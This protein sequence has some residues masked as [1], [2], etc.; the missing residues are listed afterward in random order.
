[1]LQEYSE[2]L[3]TDKP[4]VLKFY[5]SWCKPCQE[6][7]PKVI[8]VAEEYSHVTFASINVDEE[9][10]LVA[11]FGIKTVPQLVAMKNNKVVAKKSGSLPKEA[12]KDW[13]SQIFPQD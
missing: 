10:D 3:S 12:L 9:P 6:F 2:D 13:V 8:E 7:K 1:M 11:K 5:A 4:V